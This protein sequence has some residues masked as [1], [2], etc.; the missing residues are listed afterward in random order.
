M[1]SCA[2]CIWVYV[3]VYSKHSLWRVCVCPIT[4]TSLFAYAH[5]CFLCAAARLWTHPRLALYQFI[6]FTGCAAIFFAL[7]FLICANKWEIS[8]KIH[9][10]SDSVCLACCSSCWFGFQLNCSFRH[11]DSDRMHWC[12]L[13]GISALVACEQ[14]LKS[15]SGKQSIWQSVSQ[16]AAKLRVLSR[17]LLAKPA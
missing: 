12:V 2:L 11:P 15:F 9:D 14:K 6:Y 17:K 16:S 8:Q 4:L 10:A 1:Q 13:I 7:L 5:Y 3:C